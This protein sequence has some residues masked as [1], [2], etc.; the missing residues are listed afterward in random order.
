MEKVSVIITCY[1]KAE[2]IEECI[3]SVLNQTYKN[4]EIVVYNDASTDNSATIIKNLADTDDRIKFINAKENKGC[5]Y[6]RN[7]AIEKCS[8]YYIF[9]L[10]GDDLIKSSYIDKAVNAFKCNP[11]INVVYALNETLDDDQIIRPREFLKLNLQN[12]MWENQLAV[13]ALLRKED[14]YKAGQYKDY[15]AKGY[16]D[17][18]FWISCIEQNFKF[19]QLDEYLLTV[20]RGKTVGKRR[21]NIKE[22]VHYELFFNLVKHH[23]KVYTD[24]PEFLKQWIT[25][26]KKYRKYLR[27]YNLFLI[28][29]IIE[30]VVIILIIVLLHY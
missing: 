26:T 23:P 9:P 1:N 4:I 13:T 7:I 21:N 16:E 19:Y 3:K 25:N 28:V 6:A 30:F 8:G 17:W 18:E 10:D 24:T 29:S 12:L 14:F 2:F 11:E 5:V 22:K 27:L 20:R 15:M